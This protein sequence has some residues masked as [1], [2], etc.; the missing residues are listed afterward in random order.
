VKRGFEYVDVEH[1]VPIL[2]VV[3]GKAGKG[4]LVSFHDFE[5]TPEDLD[6][7]YADMCARG[8]DVV[9]IVVTPRT[10]KD[11]G[12]LLDFAT[13]RAAA[14]GTPLV[15]HA[16]GALGV[17]SRILAGRFGAPFTFASSAPGAEAAP[18]QIPARVMDELYRVRRISERTKVYG[19]A[20]G[21]V[22]KSLSPLVHNRAFA[23]CGLD[24]VYV[25][26]QTDSL[27]CLLRARRSLGLAGLSVTRPYKMEILSHLQSVD[28]EAALAGS[29]NTVVVESD[30]LRGF[31]TDGVGVVGPLEQHLPL[32]GARV[33]VLGAGGAARSAAFALR[34]EGAAVTILARDGEKAAEAARAIGCDYGPLA[35]AVERR[36][37]AAVNATPLGGGALLTETPLPASAWRAGAVAFDMVYDPRE[38]R[39]LR[40]ARAS[41]A[42]AISGLEMLLH[43]AVGQFEAWTG[44]KAPFEVMRQALFAHEAGPS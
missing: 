38:T 27:E 5:G 35:S 31:S 3:A 7:L 2:D 14:G 34:K 40:E 36:F 42:V 20:G 10:F 9:K 17:P 44:M 43:Q 28:E 21:D 30:R 26:L 1:R 16:M 12:R 29:V 13:R 22:S 33:L 32:E 11:V 23:A 6:G 15:T 18:G 24:A 37:D 41:G 4:L 8:A 19:I 39:F 25:P